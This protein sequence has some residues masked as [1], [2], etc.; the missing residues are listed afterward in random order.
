VPAGIFKKIAPAIPAI[1]RIPII[2]IKLDILK[3]LNC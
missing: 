2:K 3:L 1:I